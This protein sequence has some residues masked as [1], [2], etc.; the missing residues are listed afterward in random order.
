MQFHFLPAFLFATVAWAAAAPIPNTLLEALEAGS[1]VDL[2][3]V[4]AHAFVDERLCH[5]LEYSG[6]VLYAAKKGML[7]ETKY[8]VRHP[9]SKYTNI[10]FWTLA[11]DEA[12]EAGHDDVAEIL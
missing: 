11:R 4:G 3:T 12:R 1:R 7:E 6:A 5:E 10:L 2:H 9:C 8:L